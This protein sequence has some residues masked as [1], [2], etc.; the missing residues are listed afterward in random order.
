M[1]EAKDML[2]LTLSILSINLEMLYTVKNLT[3]LVQDHELLVATSKEFHS[4]KCYSPLCLV[5]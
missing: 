2:K 1:H 3:I 5:V 4:G